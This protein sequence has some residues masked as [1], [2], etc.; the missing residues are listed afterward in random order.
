MPIRYAG[1]GEWS[2][3]VKPEKFRNLQ[4]SCIAIPGT[5]LSDECVVVSN[6]LWLGFQEMSLYIEA[7]CIHEWSVFTEQKNHLVNSKYDRGYIYRLLTERPDNRRPLTW[8]RNQVDIL[9][10][11]GKAFK[12]PWTEKKIQSNIKYDMDHLIP[13]SLYPI[14]ELWNLVPTD[15][16]FNSHKKR[17]RLPTRERLITAEPHLKLAYQNYLSLHNTAQAIIEDVNYRFFSLE[18]ESVK[19]PGELANSVINFIDQLAIA[20][21]L[22]RF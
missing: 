4:G 1:S 8:E 6:E 16:Y 17:D 3:F 22:T 14:N 18:S 5:Q 9:L 15:P 12:C 19:F 13:V 20:R 21:N 7:L 10:I 2:V 11:E